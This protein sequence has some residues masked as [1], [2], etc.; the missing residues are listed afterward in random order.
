MHK[1][2]KQYVANDLIIT[3]IITKYCINMPD[4]E[5]DQKGVK[6]FHCG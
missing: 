2:T 6:T 1:V 5:L 3:T 4:T